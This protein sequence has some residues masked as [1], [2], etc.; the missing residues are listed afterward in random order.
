M[1][2]GK[3]LKESLKTFEIT[4]EFL[5]ERYTYN[6]VDGSLTYNKDQPPFGKKGQSAI[7]FN[8]SIRSSQVTI[9][10]RCFP[11]ARAIWLYQ[12]GAFPDCQIM[13]RDG[14]PKNLTWTNL[15]K[16]SENP[17]HLPT[18]EELRQLFNYDQLTGEMTWGFVPYYIRRVKVGDQFG[19]P[20]RR[21]LDG[22]PSHFIASL[23]GH[24]KPLTH[25]IW[26]Y[27]YGLYPTNTQVIDHIDRNPFN[28]SLS[29]LRLASQQENTANQGD[30]VFKAKERQ[31]LRGV[32]RLKTGKYISK[33]M[34]KGIRYQGEIRDTQ[35]EAHQDY[36]ELHKKLHGQYSNYV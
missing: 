11:A 9:K 21:H 33:C 4:Q 14:N 8:K 20:A 2:V 5:L 27:V 23:N 24:H 22:L 17:T 30:K 16:I 1:R 15:V 28:N 35:E 6:P 32:E 26:C 18:Q 3:T 36:V 19:C 7:S 29:N 13:C 12:T 34:C 10:G 31:R 25:F